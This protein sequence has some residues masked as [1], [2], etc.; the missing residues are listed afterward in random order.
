MIRR[1]RFYVSLLLR[2]VNWGKFASAGGDVHQSCSC[3]AGTA[4]SALLQSGDT[5]VETKMPFSI[6]AKIM[7]KWADFREIFAKMIAKI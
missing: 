3:G 4:V 2:W 1:Y 5:R 6:F 7:Q